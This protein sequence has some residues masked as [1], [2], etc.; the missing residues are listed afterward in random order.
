M[1]NTGDTEAFTTMSRKCDACIGLADRVDSIFA[2][3]GT[4]RTEG[5]KIRRINTESPGSSYSVLVDSRPT[6]YREN[7]SAP[8][9]RMPGGLTRHRVELA[10]RAG[11]WQVSYLAEF[12]S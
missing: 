7:A 1:Q 6:V 3:G 5:W 2:A 8:Q 12:N 10:R 11:E 9:T 4:I